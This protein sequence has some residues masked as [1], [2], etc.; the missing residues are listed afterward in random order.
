M[1]RVARTCKASAGSA[2]SPWPATRQRES[3][4]PCA[5]LFG[6]VVVQNEYC[7][8]HQNDNGN[9]DQSPHARLRGE[10]RF[11]GLTPKLLDES[12]R[13][14]NHPEVVKDLR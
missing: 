5:L 3:S 2:C 10:T 13:D 6:G 12:C 11:D 9:A 7:K 14:L 4:Q 1:Q 8:S